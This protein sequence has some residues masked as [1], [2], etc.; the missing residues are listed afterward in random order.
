VGRG[1]GKRAT[2]EALEAGVDMGWWERVMVSRDERGA[3]D[4]VR[5]GVTRG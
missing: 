4:V 5:V 1:E 2:G 3:S